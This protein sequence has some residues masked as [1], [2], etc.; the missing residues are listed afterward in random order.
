MIHQHQIKTEELVRSRPPGGGRVQGLTYSHAWTRFYARYTEDGETHPPGQTRP[1][2]LPDEL[3]QGYD[4]SCLPSQVDRSPGASGERGG[5][6]CR[7]DGGPEANQAYVPGQPGGTE[8]GELP[9]AFAR[10]GLEVG[11]SAALSPAYLRERVNQKTEQKRRSLDAAS[12]E[13]Q[14]PGVSMTWNKPRASLAPGSAW[15]SGGGSWRDGGGSWRDGPRRLTFQD[16]DSTGEGGA[17]RPDSATRRKSASRS[18]QQLWRP[19]KQDEEETPVTRRRSGRHNWD[20]GKM[21]FCE[22]SDWKWRFHERYGELQHPYIDTHCHID[23]IFE[24]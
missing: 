22:S 11:A 10:G 13:R 3:M 19:T 21:D 23:F 9:S 24:R 14:R 5:D 6:A 12:R 7:V 2:G 16:S 20:V 18:Q 8:C 4:P 15:R 1:P 17:A